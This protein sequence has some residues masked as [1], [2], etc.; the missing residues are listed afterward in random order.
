MMNK[1]SQESQFSKHPFLPAR[2]LE[3]I[4]GFCEKLDHFLDKYSLEFGKQGI[5]LASNFMETLYRTKWNGNVRELE[6]II[7]RAIIMA[8]GPTISASDLDIE[9]Q[10][11][12]LVSKQVMHLPYHKAKENVLISFNHEYLSNLLRQHQGNVTHAARSCGLERQ[13]LQQILRRYGL[14]AD[15]FRNSQ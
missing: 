8:Q 9:V 2:T 4:P 12:C 11:E 1:Q 6:N 15:E 13:T 3:Q 5:H 14:K 7:K 10:D